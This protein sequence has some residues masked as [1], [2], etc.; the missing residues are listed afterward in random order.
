[1]WGG[2]V[3]IQVIADSII[4]NVNALELLRETVIE[5][6]EEVDPP[7]IGH[8]VKTEPDLEVISTPYFNRHWI[9]IPK[10]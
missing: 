5:S 1:M 8:L 10:I 7:L 9:Q 2:L 3:I 6:I 4:I